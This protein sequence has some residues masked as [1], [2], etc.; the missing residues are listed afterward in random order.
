MLSYLTYK[1]R[2]FSGE[3]QFK[4]SRSSGAGGQNVNKVSTKVELRFHIASSPLLSDNEKERLLEKLANRINQ[5]GE[6]IIT[7]QSERTQLRNKT[8]VVEKFYDLL[9][10]ALTPRKKRKATKPTKGS[11]EKRLDKKRKQAQKKSGRRKD[12]Y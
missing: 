10:V 6:L 2:D 1:G 11:I 7:S 3:F 4:T 9:K 12:L 8:K 5:E